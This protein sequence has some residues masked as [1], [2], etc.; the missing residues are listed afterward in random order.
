MP[1]GRNLHEDWVV[2]ERSKER[3]C[4]RC[5]QNFFSQHA[6]ERIC[7][8]CKGSDDYQEC[9]NGYNEHGL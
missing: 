5:G 7:A 8:H 2:D 1:R 4:L 6:G 3:K 9:L